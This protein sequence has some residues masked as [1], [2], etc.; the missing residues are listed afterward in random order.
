MVQVRDNG[1]GAEL[2]DLPA[3]QASRGSAATAAGD[4]REIRGTHQVWEFD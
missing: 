2:H 1:L 4:R 3:G